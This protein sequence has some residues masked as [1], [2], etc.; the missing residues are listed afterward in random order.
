[1]TSYKGHELMFSYGMNT[2]RALMNLRCQNATVLGVAR[3]PGHQLNFR[4]HCDITRTANK[5][6]EVHGLLWQLSKDDLA[7]IDMVE[8]YPEYYIREP[9][10]VV[11]D[12]GRF[13]KT[14]FTCW[15]YI[16]NNRE[17]LEFPDERYYELVKQGYE[18]N[19][20]PINQLHDAIDRCSLYMEPNY[21]Q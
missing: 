15:T 14:V 9:V 13:P 7:I 5:N 11:Y 17:G 18:E 2:N 3:L 19:N 10:Y 20:L 21:G 16:M 8:G 6:H 1:M 12:L 4:Y